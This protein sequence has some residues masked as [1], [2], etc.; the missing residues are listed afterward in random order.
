MIKYVEKNDTKYIGSS[1]NIRLPQDFKFYKMNVT[2]M[3]SVEFKLGEKALSKGYLYYGLLY[4]KPSDEEWKYDSNYIN[5]LSLDQITSD[6]T[7][8]SVMFPKLGEYVYTFA[9]CFSNHILNKTADTFTDRL[10]K[11]VPFFIKGVKSVDLTKE[12][13]YMEMED[14]RGA[15]EDLLK[16]F[17]QVVDANN[18]LVSE[19]EIKKEQLANADEIIEQLI[20]E[21]GQMEIDFNY[22][23]LEY[24]NEIDRLM[25][26]IELL[27][28]TQGG[29]V[30]E[31]L[32]TF[33][34]EKIKELEK[35]LDD[36]DILI[37]ELKNMVAFRDKEIEK[38]RE[39]I[40]RLTKRLN[41]FE[42]QGYNINDLLNTI[43]SL[44]AEL[45]TL[46]TKY[47]LLK[48]EN[49]LLIEQL[50]SMIGDET[51]ADEAV[52]KKLQ[53]MEERY[54]AMSKA[55]ND[56]NKQLAQ[57]VKINPPVATMPGTRFGFIPLS[58]GQQNIADEGEILKD[59]NTGHIYIKDG[60]IL[61]SKTVDNENRLEEL[62]SIVNSCVGSLC[63]NSENYRTFATD[64]S[65]IFD[66]SDLSLSSNNGKFEFDKLK[67]MFN[68]LMQYN[69][70]IRTSFGS[71]TGV[72]FINELGDRYEC[73]LA[74]SSE[75]I[76]TFVLNTDEM[77]NIKSKRMALELT[78]SS[79]NVRI[80][81]IL[82]NKVDSNIIQTIN[83]NITFGGNDNTVIN[84][85]IDKSTTLINPDGS[86]TLNE[87]HPIKLNIPKDAL[88]H[89]RYSVT[90]YADGDT[91]V[92]CNMKTYFDSG[93]VQTIKLPFNEI[94]KIGDGKTINVEM[95]VP[96]H[97]TSNNRI[98]LYGINEDVK[99]EYIDLSLLRAA[100]YEKSDL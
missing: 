77:Y 14:L 10:F 33:Y 34:K 24:E 37:M 26:E 54:S 85:Y 39:E 21:K 100:D 9:Y 75:D 17:K 86:F 20:E 57:Y 16:R 73:K 58:I 59:P 97:D 71:I 82:L 70:T 12:D 65:N 74:T 90:I 22:K 72:T 76:F 66:N 91:N 51:M 31:S 6:I 68:P 80:T 83:K 92:T 47:D 13:V 89:G 36:K 29:E 45:A 32:I 23:K 96:K 62:E 4:R 11:T 94:T 18:E 87:S 95:I 69:I 52:L 55:L 88:K 35:Q 99:I 38:N 67:L 60:L 19:L 49:E 81:D 8:M 79:S 78:G 46:A 93:L 61:R 7:T 30:S 43:T 64:K 2:D 84:N 42:S 5:E 98:E 41:E 3:L 1:F 28:K 56:V 44:R 15:Y 27:L 50:N 53:L 48:K 25:G 40:D 63:I